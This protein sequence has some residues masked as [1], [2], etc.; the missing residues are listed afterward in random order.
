MILL[1]L[2]QFHEWMIST[3]NSHYEH[4]QTWAYREA[5]KRQDGNT[6]TEDCQAYIDQHYLDKV[7]TKINLADK[8]AINS[9]RNEI[10]D[11]NSSYLEKIK[12]Y[13]LHKQF[14]SWLSGE[15]QQNEDEKWSNWLQKVIW[16]Y[17]DGVDYNYSF[18]IFIKE[19]NLQEVFYAKNY[20][21]AYPLMIKRR[22][23]P[24][25]SLGFL[26]SLFTSKN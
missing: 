22:V 14:Y 17:N 26:M 8:N 6:F 1:E 16:Q 9:M 4:W 11:L 7:F 12:I 15:I 13:S 3:D 18:R 2:K 19:N 10:K 23:K 5:V 24:T 21:E 25:K 20:M